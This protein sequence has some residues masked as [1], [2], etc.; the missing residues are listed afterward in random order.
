MPRAKGMEEQSKRTMGREVLTFDSVESTNKTAAQLVEEGRAKHGT[1]VMAFEQTA[2]RGQRGR[3][4]HSQPHKD[5]TFT[6][7]MEPR[8]LLVQDQ[9]QLS[10][11]VSLALVDV[12]SPLMPGRVRIKWPNDILVDRLKVAGILIKVDVAGSLVQSVLAGMGLNVNSL[13]HEDGLMATSLLAETGREHGLADLLRSICQCL[14][15][16]WQRWEQGDGA[17][18][19]GFSD[20]LWARGRWTEVLLDGAVRQVRPIDVDPYGRLM[21]EEQDGRVAAYGTDR[22]RFGPR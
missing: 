13:G 10:Q 19:N 8:A 1:V 9:Y 5:L 15:A 4:W 11:L 6:L 16:R 22:L 14:D 2:G 3:S 7:V 21:V 18:L 20:L 17:A 12:L